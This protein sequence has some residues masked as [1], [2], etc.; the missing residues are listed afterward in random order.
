MA[1]P[2]YKALEKA[3]ELIVAQMRATLKKNKSNATGTLSKSISYTVKDTQDGLKLLI[4]ME[5][6]GGAVDGGRS[7]SKTG[8][9]KVQSWKQRIITWMRAKGIKP[10]PGV[11]IETAA[12]LITRKINR[13]GYKP[14]PFI[15]IS[16][17]KVLEDVYADLEEDMVVI[18][19]EALKAK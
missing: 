4:G 15:D 16:V 5:E 2:L 12:F 9:R 8:N 7:K 19:E 3:G 6:Y 17:K 13:E 1:Q 18:I 14:E 10:E 11:K